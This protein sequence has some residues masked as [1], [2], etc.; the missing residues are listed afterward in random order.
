MNN[1]F[2][3]Q[4]GKDT[5]VYM[6]DICIGTA[7]G[8]EKCRDHFIELG[9]G[10]FRWDRLYD[11]P[12]GEA[13]MEFR[14]NYS[15][16]YQMIPRLMYDENR[17]TRIIDRN[18]MQGLIRKMRVEDIE[19]GYIR[20]CKEENSKEPW[21]FPWWQSS[22]P[23]AAFSEGEQYAAG[24]FLPPDQMDGSFSI[25]EDERQSVHKYVWPEQAYPKIPAESQDDE[26]LEFNLPAPGI[27][28]LWENGYRRSIAKRRLF[29]V[30]ITVSQVLRP[31]TAWHKLIGQSWEMY[32]KYIPPKFSTQELWDYGFRFADSLYRRM[33]DTFESFA[34]GY[35]W[36]NNELF[37]SEGYEIGWCG[38]SAR[39]GVLMLAKAILEN[40]E[41]AHQRGIKALDSWIGTIGE[42]GVVST[43]ANKQQFTHYGRNVIDAINL[44]HA[45]DQ[46]FMAYRYARM[47][48]DE[49]PEYFDAAVGIC[50][51]AL[52]RIDMQ[53]GK[54]G[55]S[56]YEDNLEPAVEDGTCGVFLSWALCTGYKE[57]G[58]KEYLDAAEKSYM[59]YYQELMSQGYS[60]GGA[61]DIFTIDKESSIPLLSAGLMLYRLTGS[62]E[63]VNCAVDAAW[64]LSSWQWCYTRKFIPGSAMDESMY[65][66]YGGTGISMQDAWQDPYALLYVHDLY[67]LAEITGDQT[68]A[69]RAHAIWVNGMD[70]ISDGTMVID[71]RWLPAGSQH[72]ARF[73]G[74]RY[75]GPFQWL[76]SWPTAFRLSN[77]LRTDNLL[78]DRKGRV[79]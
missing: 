36:V 46:F 29:S 22:I 71:G 12:V 61:L 63:Y 56:W 26:L 39:T 35:S 30:I 50:D 37:L 7:I 65:D 4:A 67:D 32:K 27:K 33:D 16:T 9:N 24:T 51:F 49:R 19:C 28:P 18:M 3:K 31:K 57:T 5:Q 14:A 66:S 45:C 73:M 52:S 40:D 23:G 62:C 55:K 42:K 70:G 17:D 64:Y 47:L 44:Y 6:D 77:I 2:L 8:S 60:I 41:A 11:T 72:E 13:E 38:Q 54:I 74:A 69:E 20:Y 76:V 34:S 25:Y 53:T 58:R 78:G 59:F 15:M 48:G 21:I 1:T 10:V 75:Q 79:L 68:W 43:H